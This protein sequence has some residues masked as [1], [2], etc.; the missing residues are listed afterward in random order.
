V[1]EQPDEPGPA[2]RRARRWGARL[3]PLLVLA[4]GGA[5]TATAAMTAASR[6]RS[7]RQERFRDETDDV[8]QSL[9][10]TARGYEVVVNS[11][12]G[13]M[14]GNPAATRSE[15]RTLTDSVL[16]DDRFPAIFGVA[17]TQSVPAADVATMS[18]TCV[19]DL[20][21]LAPDPANGAAFVVTQAE[22]ETVSVARCIDA[23]LFPEI[24]S[25][26]GQARDTGNL[27]ISDR[28]DIPT[29]LRSEAGD[30][31]TGFMLVKPAYATGSVPDTVAERRE[32][33]IGWA[34]IMVD[35]GVFIPLSSGDSGYRY[36]IKLF[37]GK[38]ASPE[39]LIAASD[40]E[41]SADGRRREA[42]L[43]LY[44]HSWT[45]C[46]A[47]VYPPGPVSRELIT[48]IVS[49]ALITILLMALAL[50]MARSERRALRM[51]DDATGELSRRERRFGALLANA[52]ELTVVAG[53]D[54]RLEYVSPAS[55]R[56]LGRSA[57]DLIGN[58]L[59]HL[60]HPDD[61]D[62][63][64]SD[65]S[66]HVLTQRAVGPLEFRVRHLDGSWRHFEAIG[67]NRL[68][69]PAVGGIIFN[70]RDVTERKAFEHDLAHQ[71]THDALT[72]LPNRALLADRLG[73]A[74]ARSA[75]AAG[76]PLVV[77]I[78]LDRFKFVNDSLGH[79]AGDRLLSDVAD[80][81]RRAVRPGDTVARF[82]GD[83]F[84]VLAE[85]IE[86]GDECRAIADRVSNALA[87]PF[88]VSEQ[89]V[90]VSASIGM[91]LARSGRESPETLL[92]DADIAMY[93]AKERGGA[94]SEWFDEQAHVWSVDR[95]AIEN[96]L[97]RALDR[98]E[99]RLY[100]QPQHDL[101]TGRM[102]GVE[103]LLRWIHPERGLIG[104]TEFVDLA[105][106]TGLIIPI[107]EWVVRE[108]CRQGLLWQRRSPSDESFVV[109][110]NLSARQLAQGDLVDV[111]ARALDATGF[112]PASLC[113]E[114]T[115]GALMDDVTTTV[116]ALRSLK[117]LGV[118]L[119][120][121]DFG[122]GHASL[123]HLK[124]F[125]VDSLK[126]DRSFVSG[127]GLDPDDQTI[128][129]AVIGL[130]HAL[131]ITAIAEGVETPAQL[132]ELR[133]LRCDTAQGFLFSL[134]VE[135]SALDDVRTTST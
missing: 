85:G 77:F 110:V 26:L 61:A 63:L 81:I 102:T 133:A 7:D 11:I 6:E 21:A 91:R 12:H 128:V 94:R 115:E 20:A 44:G 89:E 74:V 10:R 109:S 101:M 111:I 64:V 24:K 47:E 17:W 52:T 93:R 69:D 124:Q 114:I 97:H 59:M 127:L 34:G 96:A 76:E 82:G 117:S 51:V 48:I 22:P 43:R 53:P 49:G 122:T 25:V 19:P 87:A 103:G 56:L 31:Q 3:A 68:E 65:V 33:I 70:C 71:A 105:E 28:F 92:R 30:L 95:L 14:L 58:D 39:S 123:G 36:R 90:F 121:D 79:A 35:G 116:G 107:G 75:R 99:L 62:R 27:R 15:F 50:V 104:P 4:V 108:A 18:E 37:D 86:N 2:R 132:A 45:I 9:E 66:R 8:I 135:A 78:D 42:H 119:S 134:P 100:Y 60:V 126:I 130:A 38:V 29:G 54:G 118:L 125:P 131:G 32:Q 84:V 80:R 40:K 73:Q 57:S 13:L 41:A 46:M 120:I 98:N 106:E 16:A 67:L 83:E 112:P 88:D 1:R 55:E 113:L 5:A 23:A 129:A 72:G